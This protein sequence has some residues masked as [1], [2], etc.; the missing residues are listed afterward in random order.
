VSLRHQV[1]DAERMMAP[2]AA[3]W[4]A[5][6][7]ARDTTDARRAGDLA[8]IGWD[9]ART[10][11]RSSTVLGSTATSVQLLV[12][13]EDALHLVGTY[14]NTLTVIPYVIDLKREPNGNWRIQRLAF[15]DAYD[16]NN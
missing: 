12:N 5:R 9:R 10:W 3:R 8:G 2:A 11:I 7:I 13:I 14:A 16:A 1:D 6:R 15:Q 4:F